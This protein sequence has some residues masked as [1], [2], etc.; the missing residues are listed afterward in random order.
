MEKLF[1]KHKGGR[2]SK[3]IGGAFGRGRLARGAGI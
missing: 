1:S 3:S 2:R